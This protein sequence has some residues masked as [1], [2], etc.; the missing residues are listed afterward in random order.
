M[1]SH[2]CGIQKYDTMILMIFNSF[3]KR[4]RFIDVDNKFMVIKGE[5]GVGTG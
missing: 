2:T 3:K 4:N 1:I 5:G